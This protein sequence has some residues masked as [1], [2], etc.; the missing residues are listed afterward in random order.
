MKLGK[1]VMMDTE[2]GKM[3]DTMMKLENYSEKYP[4]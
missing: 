3:G 1:R 4:S 2:L